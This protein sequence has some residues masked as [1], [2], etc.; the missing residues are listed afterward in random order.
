MT[1]KTQPFT[2]VPAD[3]V[4]GFNRVRR[5]R[6]TRLLSESQRR[7]HAER[8]H[9]VA[10]AAEFVTDLIAGDIPAYYLNEVLRPSSPQ[11]QAH[12]SQ[13]Y[14]GVFRQISQREAAF[15]ALQFGEPVGVVESLTTSDFP[16]L[17]ADVLDRELLRRF[18]EVPQA[19]RGYIN[20]GPAL[21]DFRDLHLLDIDGGTGVWD[22]ITEEEG[23]TYTNLTESEIT[24]H[25]ALYGKAI[26][27]SWRLLMSDRLDV[28]DEIPGVLARGGR[29]TV[30]RFA[31]G[32]L[33]DANGPHA[34]FFTV[35]NG[36]IITG[37]PAF[38][39]AALATAIGQMAAMTDAN[40]EPINLEAMR[41]VHGPALRVA[42]NNVLNTMTI[43][44]TAAGGTAAQVIRVNNWIAGGLT[45]VEDPY[46]PL[47]ATS[48]TGSWLLTTDPN[49]SRPA[50]EVRFLNGFESPNL[51]VKTPNT[52]T[53]GGGV[54]P[55]L[56]D[57]QSMA[58]EYKGLVAMGGAQVEPSAAVG[59]DGTG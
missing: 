35:G 45:P 31:T 48:A 10:A 56:G 33:F 39:A 30:N 59:S 32:L 16:L 40:G 2:Q 50:A 17:M 38:S 12:I 18:A 24:F 46:I 36:N 52:Q 11:I 54:V 34:S 41:L 9:R 26:R 7:A 47:I 14:P 27:L 37:S 1:T 51:Y 58:T 53:V 8:Q 42:V 25:V 5:L 43:D 23:L 15:V 19:W 55:E 13:S 22:E 3:F 20:V 44:M 57:F 49:T 6:Q 4:S 29:A 21:R 28:F